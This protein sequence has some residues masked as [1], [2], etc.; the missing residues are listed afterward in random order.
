[1]LKKL[2]SP[3]AILSCLTIAACGGGGNSSNNGSNG[4]NSGNTS[5]TSLAPVLAD[6]VLVSNSLAANGVYATIN[7]AGIVR[8]FGSGTAQ[9]MQIAAGTAPLS[10]SGKA[11]TGSGWL[12]S[13]SMF[14]QSTVTLTGNTDGTTYTLG[15]KG[16]DTQAS[17]SNMEV[18]STLVTPTLTALA[19][20]YGM[21]PWSVNINGT[22]LTGTYGTP[23]TWT[24]TLAPNGKTID[25]TNITF[26]TAGQLPNPGAITCP[27]VG[28]TYT[29]TGFL[30]GP[31][32]A[33]AKGAFDIIFDDSST[34][35]VPT[36]LQMYNFIRQ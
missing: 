11:A 8:V 32:D 23:C 10:Q 12:A 4:G 14:E 18:L 29:G 3:C 13:G 21:A 5:P 20:Q 30:L 34:S 6:N 27:Y 19:G 31:S 28:K 16:A 36:T 26:Q 22:S 2:Y 15:A 25:V 33:Y 24:A 17:A 7:Q 35:A 9:N 1:M